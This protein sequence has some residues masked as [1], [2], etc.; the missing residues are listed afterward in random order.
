M[1]VYR[2]GGLIS[3]ICQEMTSRQ[4]V[5]SVVEEAD[6]TDSTVTAS[7]GTEVTH[8]VCVCVC[9]FSTVAYLK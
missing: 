9:V 2:G 7:R 4:R 6:N 8:L 5:N 3:S 1:R